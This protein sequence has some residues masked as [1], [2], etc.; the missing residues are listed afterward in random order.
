MALRI[1]TYNVHGLPWIHCP[2][3][4][5]LLWANLKC[6]SHIICLQE[7]FTERLRQRIFAAAPKYGL[8]VFFPNEE[9]SCFGKKYLRFAVPSGLCIL[10]SAEIDVCDTGSFSCFLAS[11]GVDHLIRKGFFCLEIKY[12]GNAYQ[13]INTH[14]QSDFTELNCCRICY[15]SIR[16]IQESQLYLQNRSLSFPI[17]CGDFNKNSFRFFDRMDQ[18]HKCTF[19]QTGEHLDHLLFLPKNHA[20]VVWKK[21]TYFSDVALSDHIPVL[22]EFCI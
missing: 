7:V 22:F 4:T 6:K 16:D 21:T 9:S 14:L 1:L 10:V 8:Q 12:Q 19:P 20:A 3:E 5:I 2:I 18:D 17:V 13:I 15:D 11:A